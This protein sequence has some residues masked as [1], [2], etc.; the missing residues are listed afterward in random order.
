MAAVP[1]KLMARFQ[2]NCRP[3][4]NGCVIW[5]GKLHYKNKTPQFAPT[6]DEFGQPFWVNARWWIWTQLRCK[7]PLVL[8]A[9]YGLHVRCTCKTPGCVALAHLEVLGLEAA[10][11]RESA[12]AEKDIELKRLLWLIGSDCERPPA[13]LTDGWDRAL[14]NVLGV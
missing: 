14:V 4:K 1:A 12:L 9:M 13:P 10:I 5:K 8:K 2:S 7:D 11:G 3:G 6:F